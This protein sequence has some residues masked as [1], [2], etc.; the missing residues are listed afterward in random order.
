MKTKKILNYFPYIL[1]G[2]ALILWLYRGRHFVISDI[3][4]W[5]D[6]GFYKLIFSVYAQVI[7]SF[8]T[9]SIPYR[10]Q[11]EPLI[12]IIGNIFHAIWISYDSIILWW[13]IIISIL[14]GF[15]LYFIFRKEHKYLAIALA[16]LY[17]TS[18]VQYELF[19]RVYLK[20][21]LG[22]SLMLLAFYFTQTK[23]YSLSALFFL[24]IILLHR[25]SA[26]YAG[27]TLFLFIVADSI[28]HKK[29][30]LKLI[31]IILWAG[32]V[33]LACYTPFWSIISWWFSMIFSWYGGDFMSRNTYILYSWIPLLL[34]LVWLF[35]C[36]KNKKI[37]IFL[38]W[39]ILWIIRTTIWLVNFNR[40]I[41]FRDI[42]VLIMAFHGLVFLFNNKK[43]IW[44][45]TISWVLL[46]NTIQYISFVSHHNTAIITADEFNTLKS[47]SSTLEPSAIVMTTSKNYTP[48]VAGYTE[49]DYIA[50]WFS[51]LNTRDESRR[52]E[53]R[54]WD[55]T[56]KCLMLQDYKPLNRPIYIRLWSTQFAENLSWQNCLSMTKKFS[57]SLLYKIIYK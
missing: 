4:L 13:S 22:I 48:W 51:A 1:I 54:A 3:P 2:V 16:F 52:N 38:R 12:G 7:S 31:W 25:T 42:F 11:H 28:Q 37:D 21:I 35:A 43:R 39:Y 14:P 23:R 29:I 44:W 50:P 19:F 18:I 8:D 6:A 33:G 55:G 24:L 40:A 30:S 10:F 41:G 57:S 53:R 56:T 27:A 49:R 46:Y 20:Q 5:Y 45:T 9:S 26:L 34:S 15:I 36:I 17:R 32:L 47:F